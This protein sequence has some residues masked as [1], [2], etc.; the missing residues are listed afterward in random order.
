[1]FCAG[2]EA[3]VWTPLF[4][5]AFEVYFSIITHLSNAGCFIAYGQSLKVE[6]L[7]M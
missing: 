5:V 4:D 3:H 1:M 7:R 6:L 2:G